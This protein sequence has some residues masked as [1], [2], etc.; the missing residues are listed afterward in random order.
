MFDK[1]ETVISYAEQQVD[2]TCKRFPQSIPKQQ[3][4]SELR[5]YLLKVSEALKN[6]RS[7]ALP[8]LNPAD[9]NDDQVRAIADTISNRIVKAT[10]YIHKKANPYRMAGPA[11]FL[12]YNAIVFAIILLSFAFGMGLGRRTLDLYTD[13]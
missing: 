13:W 4:C 5:A 8:T 2:A 7:Q 11:D 12:E 10:E 1:P 6:E 3:E 9:Y